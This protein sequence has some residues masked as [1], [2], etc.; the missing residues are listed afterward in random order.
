[1]YF[2]CYFVMDHK[3]FV[4]NIR[5]G[6]KKKCMW[7]FYIGLILKINEQENSHIILKNG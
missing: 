2:T 5:E 1:M 7:N 4:I 6:L 3:E